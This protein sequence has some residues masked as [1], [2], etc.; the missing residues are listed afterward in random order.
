MGNGYL[1]K[2]SAI[3]TANTADF[4]P[5]LDAAAK[6]VT[7][8]AK[9]MQST[10]TSASTASSTALRGIYTE[11][12]RFERAVKAASSQKLSFKGFDAASLRDAATAARQL[13]SATAQ[14][15]QPLAAA[16]KAF[17]RLSSDVQ[18]QFLPALIQAQSATENLANTIK[19]AGSVSEQKFDRIKRRVDAATESM[20]RLAQ[21]E[22]LVNSLGTGR[23]LGFQQPGLVSE[24]SRSKSLQGKALGLSPDQLSGSKIVDLVTQQRAAAAEAVKLYSALENVRNTRKGDAALAETALNEQLALYSQ[25][26]AQIE[27]EI[28]GI[29]RLAAARKRDDEISQN[30]GASSRR[31]TPIASLLQLRDDEERRARDA[32]IAANIGQSSRRATPIAALLRQRQ[33]EE[34]QANIGASTRYSSRLDTAGVAE[35]QARSAVGGDVNAYTEQLRALDMAGNKVVDL[36]AKIE[37]LPDSVRTQFVPS[38]QDAIEAFVRL[39]RLGPAATRDQIDGANEMLDQMAARA[40]RVSAGFKFGRQFGGA[41]TVGV[42][43]GIDSVQMGGY[44]AQ[45]QILQRTL[46]GVASEARGPGVAAFNSLRSY[47][48]AA[49]ADGTIGMRNTREE[50]ERLT[51]EA[52]TAT[53]RVSGIGR[54]ALSRNVGRAGDIGRGG[55]DKFALAVQQAGFAVDDFFSV[56]GGFDQR[57]RAVG[58]NLTQLGFIIGGT[59]GLFSALAVTAGSQVALMFGKYVLQLEDTETIEKRLKATTDSLNASFDSQAEAVERLAE[60]YR[61][62]Q[63]GARDAVLPEKNKTALDRKENV[64]DVKSRQA[65]SRRELLATTVPEIAKLRLERAQMEQQLKENAPDFATQFDLRQRIAGNKASEDQIVAQFEAAAAD[66]VRRKDPMLNERTA[67]IFANATIEDVRERNRL[68]AAG[69]PTGARDALLERDAGIAGELAVGLQQLKDAAAAM[70]VQMSGPLSDSIA[71]SQKKIEDAGGFVSKDARDSITRAGFELEDVIKKAAAGELSADAVKARMGQIRQGV[72]NAQEEIQYGFDFKSRMEANK[73]ALEAE[74]QAVE[75]ST[76]RGRGLGVTPAQ[77]AADELRTGLMDIRRGV[78]LDTQEATGFADERKIA[79]A[80]RN[81]LNARLRDAAPDIFKMAD[82]VENAIVQGPSRAALQ[83]TDVSTSQGA[84]ELNRL[85]R[86][87]DSAKDQNLAELQKQSKS[88]DDLVTIARENAGVGV[89]N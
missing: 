10:L 8:F 55:A 64:E 74:Q 31:A 49:A 32:E 67:G 84:A 66:R 62:M 16:S 38:V 13:Y 47:I 57:I 68:V 89:W 21:A 5:K 72:D 7:S 33:N 81:F 50:I 61:K 28:D 86:G 46:A 34:I 39:N 60:A 36:R 27:R 73:K 71:E 43:Q 35:R 19:T 88:L 23:E 58:N 42:N 87:D 56:T 15:T 24:M 83:A 75:S 53:A 40:D 6:D 2:I 17:G 63:A 51:A 1:G 11:A 3:V 20:S 54:G 76:S 18:S 4:K 80:Q 41:G 69:A 82:E 26:N 70:A 65:D 22:S 48:S 25:V 77:K 52:V 12:Q 29:E 9:S 30:I 85:L 79:D 14:V 44:T 37:T 59:A 78:G 45:L